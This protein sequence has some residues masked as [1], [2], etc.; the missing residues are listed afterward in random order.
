MK[1]IIQ[2][3]SGRGPA[4][5]N[6]VVTNVLKKFLQIC[7]KNQV[8]VE[9]LDREIDSD[10]NLITSVI[11]SLEADDLNHFLMDW[12]KSIPKIS[13]TKKLVH[14][15]FRIRNTENKPEIGKR[16][17]VSNHAQFRKWWTKCE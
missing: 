8:Q 5:C 12:K 17:C 10:F 3:T 4:E 1:K 7:E 15:L 16:I 9:V 14:R 6:Y 11:L 2:L 13:C